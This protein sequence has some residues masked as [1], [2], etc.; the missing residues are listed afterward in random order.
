MPKKT[1][2]PTILVAIIAL[3]VIIAG[4]GMYFYN[5]S[6]QAANNPNALAK[7]ELAGVTAAVGKLMVLPTNETPSLATVTDKNTLDKTQSFFAS[8]ENGDK[9]LIYAQAMKA[10]LYRPSTNKIIEVAPI[11]LSAAAAQTAAAQKPLKIAYYNG[12]ETAGVTT[13]IEGKIQSFF[14][15]QSLT[16][17]V[18]A[19]DAANKNYPN[20][21]V[22]DLTGKNATSS[23]VIAAF[24]SGKVGSLPAGEIAPS[25]ADVLIILGK[26]LVVAPTAAQKPLKIAYYNGTATAGLAAGT[27]E[28]IQGTF[29]AQGLTVTASKGD[30]ANKNY[31]GDL[32]VDLTGNNATSTGVIATFLSGKV[33]SLPPGETAPSGAD[34]LIILGK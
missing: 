7:Q 9:L 1:F 15:S 4:L 26:N 30:A 6:R 8:A 28:K 21:L 22:V 34:V 24:L 3:I 18:S 11:D 32:V 17:T 19:G 20:T 2:N 33:G 29:G 25:G 14:G 10:I 31:Q 27:E 13:D 16:T 23:Q 12:T 5:S